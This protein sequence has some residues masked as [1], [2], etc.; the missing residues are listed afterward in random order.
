MPEQ[1]STRAVEIKQQRKEEESRGMGG[2]II[3]TLFIEG[4]MEK[5]VF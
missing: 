4:L 2:N 5:V 1:L 3:N